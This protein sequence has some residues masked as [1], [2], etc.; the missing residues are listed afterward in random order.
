LPIVWL[1]IEGETIASFANSLHDRTTQKA[2]TLH[3][4][5]RVEKVYPELSKSSFQYFS[6][7]FEGTEKGALT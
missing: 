6:R 5:Y 2:Q 4:S 7:Q 1:W 3:R